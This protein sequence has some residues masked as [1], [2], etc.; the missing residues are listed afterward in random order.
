MPFNSECDLVARP[1]GH[2]DFFAP[3]PIAPRDRGEMGCARF[4]RALEG[5]KIDGDQPETSSP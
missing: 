2:D 3:N 1:T 5:L 4:Q